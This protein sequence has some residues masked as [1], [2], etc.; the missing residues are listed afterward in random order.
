MLILFLKCIENE[1]FHKAF[2]RHHKRLSTPFTLHYFV[3]SAKSISALL[4]LKKLSWW[5]LYFTYMINY[6]HIYSNTLYM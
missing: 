5:T 6:E 4:L 2:F 3:I 1:E